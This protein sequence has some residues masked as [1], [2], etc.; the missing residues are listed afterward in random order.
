MQAVPHAWPARAV[1]DTVQ[2]VLAQPA[3][4]RDLSNTI[5]DRLLLWLGEALSKL[6][7]ALQGLPGGRTIAIS[8]AFVLVALVVARLL[9]AAQARD[10]GGISFGSRGRSGRREDPWRAAEGLAAAG[11]FEGAAH[12]LYRGVLA[13]LQQGEKLRLDP[14]KTS[15]DYARE[16]RARG[17]GALHPFRAFARRFDVAVYGHGVCDAALYDDL[18]RLSDPLRQRARAA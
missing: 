17:S 8:V 14:S 1:H 7:H 13:S 12:A 9:I 10:A 4:R 6:F 16:L 2:A 11:D 18:R 3:F 15:G 5:L